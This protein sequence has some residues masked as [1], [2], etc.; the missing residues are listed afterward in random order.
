M[1][2]IN[3][4]CQYCNERLSSSWKPIGVFEDCGHL[5]HQ[6]YYCHIPYCLICKK[7]RKLISIDNSLNK[8]SHIDVMSIKRKKINFNFIDKL[9]GIWRLIRLMPALLSLYFRLYFNLL[10]MNYLY[11]FNE[12]LI[13]ILNINIS[14]SEQSQQRLLDSSY[15]RIIISNHTNYHDTMVIGSLLSPTNNF[16][17]IASNII[18]TNLFGK[19]I[20][21]IMP[22]III[23][24]E[25]IKNELDNMNEP[26]SNYN[27]I[28]SY[29]SKYPNETRLMIFPEGMLTHSNTIT[30]FRSTAFR[31]GYPVQPVILKYKQDIF[32]LLNFDIFCYNKIDVSVNVLEPI[33]TDGS[34]ESIEEIRNIM[35]KSGNFF[36]SNVINKKII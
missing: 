36:L 21:K 31:L 17:F 15:K 9:R 20:T 2:E 19:A 29:F 30:K 25:I 11:W 16:G 35:A 33:K 8:Q 27:K 23:D 6:T 5:N 26:L 3:P 24:N 32:D 28:A 4:Y 13:K 18:N 14:C 12:F 1:I 22:N 7:E 34:K 10:D